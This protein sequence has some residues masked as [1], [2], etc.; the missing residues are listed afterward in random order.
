MPDDTTPGESGHVPNG[1]QGE[2]AAPPENAAPES[3][4]TATQATPAATPGDLTQSV[5]VDPTR[6]IPASTTPATATPATASGDIAS[7]GIGFGAAST[8]DATGGGGPRSSSPRALIIALVVVAVLVVGAG[9]ALAVNAGGGNKKASHNAANIAAPTTTAAAVGPLC[10]LTGLAPTGGVVPQRPALAVKVDDYPDARPQSGIDQADIVF[11]EPVEG[12]ITRFAAVFQC[13]S[14]SLI[15]PIRSA[16]A[17]DL[18]I[19]DQLSKPILVHVGGINPVLSMLSN[20]NLSDFDLRIHGSIIKHLPGR[21]AP[22]DTYISAAAGWGLEAD[23]T[24]PPTPLF[25]YSPTTTLGAAT[26]SVHIPFTATNNTLWSWDAASGHWL[27]SYSGRP[28]TVSGGGQIATTN[29]VVQTVHVTYGPWLENSE[30]GLEVQSQMT[31]SGPV[32]V[33]RDGVAITGT[34]KRAALG[35]PTT[36]TATNGSTIALKP[37]QTWVEIV[38]STVPVTTTGPTASNGPATTTKP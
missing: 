28:A 19:L 34:W 3:W 31:G 17:V 23:D 10:P 29:I 12:G 14:P 13:Q 11:D 6:S 33:L 37:G 21:V 35:D 5:P 18:Q 26:G 36:L 38:P 27:L 16:R 1:D 2:N 9:I 22:Y 30:G 32:L 7:N 15:G 8:A 4:D 25:T 20:G 24:T